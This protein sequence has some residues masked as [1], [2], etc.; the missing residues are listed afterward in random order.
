M[1][2]IAWA[3]VCASC[4]ELDP[5]LFDVPSRVWRHYIEPAKREK[6]ICRRCFDE[7]AE[8]VDAG[9]YMLR[10]G[11]PVALWSVAHRRR[12]GIPPDALSPFDGTTE[13]DAPAD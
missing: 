3:N 12:H 10:H 1:A 4:G 6:I 8:L 2:F 5:A 11:L 13:A 9:A 7:I